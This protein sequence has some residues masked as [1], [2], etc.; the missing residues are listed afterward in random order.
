VSSEGLLTLESLLECDDPI[1]SKGIAAML[2]LEQQSLDSSHLDSSRHEASNHW[3]ARQW[4]VEVL[5]D[6]LKQ[7]AGRRRALIGTNEDAS[8]LLQAFRTYAYQWY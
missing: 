8:N 1:I 5:R 2:T 7:S 4:S 6:Q 3:T